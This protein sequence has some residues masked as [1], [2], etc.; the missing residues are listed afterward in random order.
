MFFEVLGGS[1]CVGECRSCHA[2]VTHVP[3]LIAADGGRAY[4]IDLLLFG[5]EGEAEIE[6]SAVRFD[7]PPFA[8]LADDEGAAVLNHLPTSWGHADD[9]PDDAEPYRPA[10]VAEARGRDLTPVEVAERRPSD[11]GRARARAEARRRRRR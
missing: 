1:L 5:F 4:L 11:G 3:D 9:L 2:Q 7:H 10:E 8:D 6:G